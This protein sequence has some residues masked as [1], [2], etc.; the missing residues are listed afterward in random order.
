M[1]WKEIAELLLPTVGALVPAAA[2][3]VP[4]MHV[5]IQEADALFTD[6]TEKAAHVE[7][8]VATGA[9]AA[10]A[11]GKVAIDPTTAVGITRSV[12]SIIDSVHQVL[13]ANP[14]QPAATPAAGA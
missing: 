10:T 13:K 5:G 3:Y 8:L 7:N 4:L 1:K 6:G 11:T 12:F 14:P 9:A 2:P